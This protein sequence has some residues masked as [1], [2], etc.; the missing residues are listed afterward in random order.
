M[1]QIGE[2][3]HESRYV[4]HLFHRV[5]SE[6]SDRFSKFSLRTEQQVTLQI[7]LLLQGLLGPS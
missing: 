1:Q 2:C 3:T 4:K 7:P 5:L 6:I